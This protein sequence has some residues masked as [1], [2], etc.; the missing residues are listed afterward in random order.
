M[1]KNSRIFSARKQQ[2]RI[3]TFSGDFT[4]NRDCFIFEF[5]HTLL[6]FGR[7][8]L[9]STIDHCHD[10]PSDVVVN[11]VVT[12]NPHSVL[13]WPDQRPARL[14]SPGATGRVHGQHPIDG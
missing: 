12:C 13:F 14:S 3:A 5:G 8:C 7:R 6:D 9:C 2:N 11:F 10:C 1:Q 4:D